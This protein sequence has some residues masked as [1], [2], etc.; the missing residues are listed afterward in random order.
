MD[1]SWSCD[2]DAAPHP[3][4]NCN[5]P[6]QPGEFIYLLKSHLGY[7]LADGTADHSQRSNV[8]RYARYEVIG[9]DGFDCLGC[10]TELSSS[11]INRLLR[12]N[13][14]GIE[15]RAGGLPKVCMVRLPP[16]VDVMY[17]VGFRH[18]SSFIRLLVGEKIGAPVASTMRIRGRNISDDGIY[19]ETE[20]TWTT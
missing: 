19:F 8:D 13:T 6:F 17:R 11:A 2:G 5:L 10:Y 1:S 14:T 16:W 20:S 7:I 3:T 12:L 15:E 9:C 4:S 18:A